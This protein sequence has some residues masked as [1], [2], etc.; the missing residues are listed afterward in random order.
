MISRDD[1][2]IWTGGPSTSGVTVRIDST[3]A[4]RG[5][6]AR[7]SR[8]RPRNGLHPQQPADRRS[9]I[10][11]SRRTRGSSSA[12]GMPGAIEA[13]A[14]ARSSRRR[15][16]THERCM[17][18]VLGSCTGR[19]ASA[20]VDPGLRACRVDV[21]RPVRV[22]SSGSV[23]ASTAQAARQADQ[24][25]CVLARF[26]GLGSST[27]T[28]APGGIGSRDSSVTRRSRWAAFGRKQHA[29]AADARRRPGTARK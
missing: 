14:A 20:S 25:E 24:L 27:C 19:F 16:V 10:H 7:G 21:S 17:A 23:P 3:K 18:C 22:A 13:S 2:R 15:H 28:C 29:H 9:P 6:W 1:S 4:R 26:D 11:V 8:H 12:P 5:E